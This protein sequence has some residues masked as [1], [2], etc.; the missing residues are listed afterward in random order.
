MILVKLKNV[1]KKII[2]ITLTEMISGKI[3]VILV[4]FTKGFSLLKNM[5]IDTIT[6]YKHS[7]ITGIKTFDQTEA[8]II[9]QYHA[10]EKGFLHEKFKFRFG[11]DRINSLI[12]L[13]KSDNIDEVKKECTQIQSACIALCKYYEKH[14]E[15]LVD[16]TDYYSE[17]D[18]LYFKSLIKVD[19]EIVKTNSKYDYF[20]NIHNDFKLFA[21]SRKS[22][23]KFTGEIIPVETINKV[24]EIAKTAPSVCNRQPSKVYL[25]QN[26][27]LVDSIFRIQGGLTGYTEN[28]N[29]L[30]VLTS[31]RNYFYS[32][33]ERNQLYIDGGIFLMNL[34]YS[35]HY[36]GIG[37]CSAHWAMTN[38][39]DSKIQKLINLNKSEKVICIISIGIP[40]D[41]IT[42]TLSKR[43]DNSEIL[44]IIE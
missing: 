8:A 10:I 36:Y 2:G 44:K 1:L 18:Y 17:D 19:E 29:Q 12:H 14:K 37:A 28:V 13:L 32:V 27:H 25:I 30:I 43:R 35:F 7:I 39:E 33:G 11:K 24:I 42:T 16:I 22:I 3:K 23:R 6:Y 4:F 41:P 20:E 9:L 26:K 5:I 34:L 38:I 40:H 21:S 15:N 31:D